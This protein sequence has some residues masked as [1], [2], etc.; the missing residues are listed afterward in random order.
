MAVRVRKLAKELNRDPYDVIGVLHALGASRY[1]SPD[2]MIPDPMVDRVKRAWKE[3]IE[4]LPVP[5]VAVAEVA[6]PSG[7]AKEDLMSRLVPGV[8]RHGKQPT[9]LAKSGSGSPAPAAPDRGTESASAALVAERGALQAEREALAAERTRL[10]EERE[11]LAADR[12]AVQDAHAAL[13]EERAALQREREGLAAA[14]GAGTALTAVLDARGLRGQDEHVRAL[15]ALAAS[16]LLGDLLPRLRVED[17]AAAERWLRER[18]VLT[19]GAV[20][21]GLG[22][23]VTV[24]PERADLPDAGTLQRRIARAGELL[25]LNGL[26][27]LLVVG[28]RTQWHRLL[29]AGMDPRIEAKFQAALRAEPEEPTDAILLWGVTVPPEVREAVGRSFVIE[30]GAPD[31]VS[32]LDAIERALTN[33]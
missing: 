30:A 9:K 5:R 13:E 23:A 11:G 18:L 33:E 32:L 10:R 27:R 21:E 20:P 19:G 17:P 7:P 12:A 22:A 15:A 31:L 24:A 26:R 3:G 28:G 29:K 25:L 16:R 1:R 4:P 6:A 8:V 2:D 14:P